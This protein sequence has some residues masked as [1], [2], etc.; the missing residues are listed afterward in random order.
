MSR[1]LVAISL[2]L[3]F[4]LKGFSS[5][6]QTTSK[7]GLKVG[8]NFNDVSKASSINSSNSQG[9]MAGLIYS[10]VNKKL[11]GYQSEV[12]FSRQGYDFKTSTSSGEVKLD[13]LL[14]PQL[15]N[16]NISKFI[17][18]Q[19]G[20]QVAFLVGG[21]GDSTSF[22]P[23]SAPDGSRYKVATDYFNRVLYGFAGGVEIRP[24]KGLLI[25]GRIN[26]N[27]N[28]M[29]EQKP[30]GVLPPYLPRNGEALKMNVLQLYAG[31][32]F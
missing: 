10:S 14:L 9:F 32:Q 4:F 30:S 25:G 12:L 7:F 2:A 27:F 28:S 23:S 24:F 31:W 19:A 21:R 22:N 3:I 6:A 26:A 20:G 15:V 1:N 13:Y 11:I 29:Q 5:H 16:I 17:R 8:I 18:L